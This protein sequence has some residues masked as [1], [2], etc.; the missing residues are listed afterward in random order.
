[1]FNGIH[2]APIR[3]MR[4]SVDRN[5][6]MKMIQRVAHAFVAA[7]V[8]IKTLNSK[9]FKFIGFFSSLNQKQQHRDEEKEA[10]ERERNGQTR[11][12]QNLDD[13]ERERERKI[14]EENIKLGKRHC[15][16]NDGISNKQHHRCCCSLSTVHTITLWCCSRYLFRVS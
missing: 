9:P 8:K 5:K 1:M 13:R 12:I 16:I 2:T 7:S 4:V 14:V 11:N 15:V 3:W 10:K 6:R